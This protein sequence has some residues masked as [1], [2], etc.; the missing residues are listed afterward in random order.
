MTEPIGSIPPRAPGSLGEAPGGIA[1]VVQV[2]RDFGELAL[3]LGPQHP[4][5]HGVLRLVLHLR[6]DTP[7]HP[8]YRKQH[9][10]C[11]ESHDP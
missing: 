2:E 5:T 1:G 6:G 9:P 3:N 4:S 10:K 11:A 7:R 8:H